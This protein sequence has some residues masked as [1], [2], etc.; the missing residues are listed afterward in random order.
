MVRFEKEAPN[1]SASSDPYVALEHRSHLNT[2]LRWMYCT[3][4]M[5][6]ENLKNR[7]SVGAVL[8]ENWT[9]LNGPG[10]KFV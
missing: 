8:V 6:A 2:L 3:R 4:R 1:T 7:R 5:N 10:R 9:C